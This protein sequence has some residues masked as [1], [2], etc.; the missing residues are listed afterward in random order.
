MN[1]TVTI[2]KN[3]TTTTTT[4]LVP[5]SGKIYMPSSF[6]NFYQMRK[7]A[8]FEQAMGTLFPIVLCITLGL[9]SLNVFNRVLLRFK[10]EKYQ[11]GEGECCP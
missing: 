1:E 6:S 8:G 4:Q 2:I 10:L 11:F 5:E 3:G 7:I 9:F